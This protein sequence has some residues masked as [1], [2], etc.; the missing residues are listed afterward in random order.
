MQ[1]L[2]ERPAAGLGTSRRRKLRALMGTALAAAVL[3]AGT[4]AVRGLDLMP[5]LPFSQQTVDRTGPALMLALE[6]LAEYHAAQ[7]SFQVAVD[8][9]KDSQWLPSVISGERTTYLASGSVDGIVD[10]TG[11]D[12][13]AVTL[14]EDGRSVTISLPKPRLGEVRI[15]PANSRVIARDRGLLDRVGG[16]FK[17]NPTSEQQL[18][19]AAQE[20]M[21]R[22]AAES[23][24]LRR[25]EDNT[26]SM[27]TGLARSLG[28]EDV[29]VRFDAADGL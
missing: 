16:A 9:E 12:A 4:V 8:I 24:L 13:G 23:D 17:D 25:S 18:Q 1:V 5:D 10:F 19:L 14:S 2:L 21:A 15:D 28:V 22:A 3:L 27:L 26:R 20:K 6:D 11:L 29:T 7:G